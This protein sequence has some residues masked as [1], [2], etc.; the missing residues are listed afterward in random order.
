MWMRNLSRYAKY[1]YFTNIS[2]LT[3]KVPGGR[4]IVVGKYHY[5]L[6]LVTHC[7][8]RIC[9]GSLSHAMIGGYFD[10]IRDCYYHVSVQL[11]M[12]RS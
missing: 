2:P 7:F 9:V 6:V 3:Q 10:L 11:Q 4:I 1:K 5:K 8:P 12:Q